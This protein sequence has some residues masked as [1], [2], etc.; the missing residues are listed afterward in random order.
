ML[1]KL[2]LS[3]PTF[4]IDKFNWYDDNINFIRLLET[5]VL[6][7]KEN[8]NIKED[9]LTKFGLHLNN[10]ILYPLDKTRTHEKK[11]KV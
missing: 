5:A 1:V 7:F 11:I 3:A 10:H 9:H 4:Q 6:T 2:I 8:L